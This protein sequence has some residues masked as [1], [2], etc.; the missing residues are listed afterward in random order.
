M[1]KIVCDR[2]GCGKE[3]VN[4]G[5][6]LSEDKVYDLCGDCNVAYVTL[7]EKMRAEEDLK[8]KAWLEGK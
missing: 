5:T 3:V 7:W 1:K 6:L 4:G 2:A 8:V